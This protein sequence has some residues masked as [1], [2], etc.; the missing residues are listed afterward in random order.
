MASIPPSNPN[1]L[2]ISDPLSEEATKALLQS[3]R[4]KEGNWVAWGQA[5]QQL[6][7]AGLS[8]QQI[9]EETG[10]EPS[11]QNQVIVAAQVYA[12]LVSGNAA[13]AVLE[14]FEQTGSD[15]LYELRI[16]TQ[17]ERVAAAT[18]LVEKGIDSEGAHE[19]AKALKEYSRLSRPPKAFADYPDD[20][21][22]HFYWKLARQQADLQA[23]SRLIAQA[24]RFAK[25]ETARQQV[26]QLLTDF[27]ISRS[28]SAPRL[29]F[30]RLESA[31]DQGRIIPVV[32]KLP[33]TTADLQAVPI[34]EPEGRFH[35]V[36]FAG[37]GAWA[38]L[39]GWQVVLTAE[40][41]ILLLAESEQ[42]PGADLD[43]SESEEV[44]LL[45]DRAQRD[46][47]PESYFIVDEAGQIQLDWFEEAP[48]QPILGK[49]TLV[50]RPQKVL[51]EGYNKE[52]WQIDE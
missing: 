6:Q 20:A 43:D 15:S 8:Q 35:I 27:S 36:K 26:E 19:V 2:P 32:G 51:D 41:P 14:R 49:L 22:A 46:W 44:L 4:R 50:L 30:Y 12:S 52:L 39:P 18:L 1:P 31:S 17:S 25:S 11:Q 5:C 33:L 9:F 3:L 34:V 29:P 45:V 38:A 23:R 28:R 10:F 24:L 37:T 21:V 13:A 16:L 48:S 40:D 42:L 7:K 47:N